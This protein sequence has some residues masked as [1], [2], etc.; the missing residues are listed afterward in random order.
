M[1]Y[2]CAT[3]FPRMSL[4]IVTMCLLLL[5]GCSGFSMARAERLNGVKVVLPSPTLAATNGGTSGTSL[6]DS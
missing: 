3:G 5:A 2:A 4:W 6:R 1:V